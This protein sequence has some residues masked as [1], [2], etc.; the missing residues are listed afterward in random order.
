MSRW[1]AES[2]AVSN[3]TREI[4]YLFPLSMKIEMKGVDRSPARVPNLA[5]AFT[6]ALVERI[7][8]EFVAEGTG[9]LRSTVGPEALFHYIYAVLSSPEYRRRYVDFL[10]SDFPRVPLPGGRSVFCRLSEVGECLTR[11]SLMEAPATGKVAW[12]QTEGVLISNWRVEKVRFDEGEGEGRVWINQ[13]ACCAEVRREVWEFSVGGYRPARKWLMDRKGDTLG[14]DDLE[15]YRI[16]VSAIGETI[17]RMREVDEIIEAHGGWPDAFESPASS[18]EAEVLPFQRLEERPKPADRYRDCVP[19]VPLAA[20][21]GGFGEPQFVDE[22]EEFEWVRVDTRRRLRKGMFVAQ[23]VGKSMEPRI[24]DGAWCLFRSPVTG[25]RQGRTL[26]VQLRDAVDPDTGQRYTVKRY[27]SRRVRHG[28]SWR[29]ERI[30]L[31]PVNREFAPIEV[32]E[33]DEVQFIAELVEVL[34]G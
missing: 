22:R 10:K 26:L 2:C 17:E 5:K 8:L 28:D 11:L 33:E 3:A 7:G 18:E 16:I 13:G 15:H 29:H 30:R 6:D 24:P 20:A 1:V 23:V 19:L 21:A 34:G 4:G 31:L 12:S 14:E 25:T 32:A 27:E 9:D